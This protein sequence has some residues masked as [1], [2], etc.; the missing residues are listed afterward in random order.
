MIPKKDKGTI[1]EQA[2]ALLEGREVWRGSGA[3]YGVGVRR[4]LE[5]EGEADRGRV[6]GKR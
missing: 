4:R 6:R 3:E 2:R 5:G 1:A